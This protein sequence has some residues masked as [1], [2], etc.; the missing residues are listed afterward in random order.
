LATNPLISPLFG[1]L[2]GLPSIFIN[3]GAYDELF[4]DGEKFYLK[5]RE[6]GVDVTFREG[7]GQVHCYPLLAPMFPEATEAMNEIVRFIQHYLKV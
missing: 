6:A 5:A 4:D 3:S 1:N 7:I 2:V